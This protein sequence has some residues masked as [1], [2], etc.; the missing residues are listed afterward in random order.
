MPSGGRDGRRDRDTRDADA[1]EEEREEDEAPRIDWSDVESRA[2]ANG[3][4]VPSDIVE[5]YKRQGHFDLLRRQVLSAFQSPASSA[6]RDTQSAIGDLLVA[7][8]A[9]HPHEAAKIAKMSDV[10]LQNSE[11]LRILDMH[12]GPTEATTGPE[13][14]RKLI[15]QL[16]EDA[17]GQEHEEG[18]RGILGLKGRLGQS[19]A[20]EVEHLLRDEIKD[21]ERR[22]AVDERVD[23]YD[24]DG[25][26]K[27][28]KADGDDDRGAE[29]GKTGDDTGTGTK[30][31][32]AVTA[33]VDDKMDI[34]TE[35]P[36]STGE[37]AVSASEN[38]SVPAAT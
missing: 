30:D 22:V 4:V 23:G 13:I 21:G 36:T 9:Q 34:D 29:T 14:M 31:E 8:F 25:S 3:L 10:R 16:Q 11:C 15:D 38:T 1:A 32:A 27:A 24:G 33:D 5:E 19:I 12:Q 17:D 35:K 18:F 7:Y 28:A 2:R 6:K 20:G 37:T 26:A